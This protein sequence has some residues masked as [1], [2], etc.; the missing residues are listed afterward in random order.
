MGWFHS[1]WKQAN[2]F[3]IV[4]DV[5]NDL[6]GVSSARKANEQNVALAKENRDFEERMSNTSWQRGVKDMLAAG[7]N[8]MLA[9]SQGGASTPN[10]SA[11]SVQSENP[12]M[13]GHLQSLNSA[14]MQS[15]QRDQMQAQTQVLNEQANNLRA[16]TDLARGTAANQ[17]AT[18]EQIWANVDKLQ[19]E[20]DSI[21]KDVASKDLDLEQK[22]KVQAI[23]LEML[24]LERDAKR[25]NNEALKVAVDKATAE[26]RKWLAEKGFGVPSVSIPFIGR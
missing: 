9:V 5:W 4:K 18:G 20:T 21:R 8:P 14:R 25:M 23:N 13:L 17:A 26:W 1:A 3:N 7:I 15:L 6:T 11:A 22:Q 10:T 12:N 2:P 16:Q 24:Q 19:W